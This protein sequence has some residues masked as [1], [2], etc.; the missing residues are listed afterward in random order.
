MKTKTGGR[1]HQEVPARAGRDA[2][3][4]HLRA[5]EGTD[6]AEIGP[7]MQKRIR[8]PSPRLIIQPRSNQQ[9]NQTIGTQ[10]GA[11]AGGLRHRAGLPVPHRGPRRGLQGI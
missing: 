9:T 10:G 3:Q 1:L 4:I 5:L 11:G 7:S 2:H 8:I 6:S